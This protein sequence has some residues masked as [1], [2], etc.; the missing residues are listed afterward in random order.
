MSGT[1]LSLTGY[2]VALKT[3]WADTATSF[4]MAFSS[5]PSASPATILVV[6][7]EFLIRFVVS[8]ELRDA[9]FSVV[10]AS[11]ADEALEIVHSGLPIGLIFSDVRMPGS[12]DGLELLA[13]LQDLSSPVPMIITSGHL[14]PTEALSR[15]AVEFL[16][17]PYTGAQA[18]DLIK[19]VLE[20]N[21]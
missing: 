20:T 11:N 10:E 19:S 2:P 15:G 4:S 17:K 13:H 21:L 8:D 7:D 5:H 14:L 9:G 1:C 3:T 16:G 18:V 12:M 6:E